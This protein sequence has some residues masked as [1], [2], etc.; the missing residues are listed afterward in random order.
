MRKSEQKQLRTD[1]LKVTVTPEEKSQFKTL[2]NHLHTD[3][4]ELVRQLLHSK[5]KQELS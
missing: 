3:I 4:S 2:A 1:Y 5:A